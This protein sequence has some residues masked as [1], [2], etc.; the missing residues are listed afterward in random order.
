MSLAAGAPASRMGA[1]ASA[2]SNAGEQAAGGPEYLVESTAGVEG[3]ITAGERVILKIANEAVVLI[4]PEHKVSAGAGNSFSC[5][6]VRGPD[7]GIPAQQKPLTHFPYH[8]IMCWGHS[9]RTFQFR[10]FR[11]GSD[12]DTL[13]FNTSEGKQLETVLLST[14]KSLMAD[15]E[16]KAVGDAEF[17]A[18]LKGI[19]QDVDPSSR[20]TSIKQF[21][22]GHFFIA[23]HGVELLRAVAPDTFDMIEIAAEMYGRI[24]NKDMFQLMLNEF[25]SKEDRE[26]VCYRLGIKLE[27]GNMSVECPEGLSGKP[28]HAEYKLDVQ[29]SKA[30]V[31]ALKQSDEILEKH[32]S[33]LG[34]RIET[35]RVVIKRKTE[36]IGLSLECRDC[37]EFGGHQIIVVEEF[38]PDM[39]AYVAHQRGEIMA[40]DLLL[41]VNGQAVVGLELTKVTPLFKKSAD[42]LTI[43]FGRFP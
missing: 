22:A 36:D 10:V 26:N 8:T 33:K 7:C 19:Q 12:P 1:G 13:R 2:K 29:P 35:V 21:I 23:R 17:R 16:A 38:V 25:S 43:L 27:D 20:L 11:D 14:V 41:Q 6:V 24:I 15:M 34:D 5:C 4:H 32:L 40:G 3:V 42:D 39:P 30:S 28:K 9:N 37:K 18:L 31:E